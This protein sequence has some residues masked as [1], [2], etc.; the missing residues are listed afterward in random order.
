MDTLKT[1][2]RLRCYPA[3]SAHYDSMAIACVGH[4]VR[5]K[6]GETKETVLEAAVKGEVTGCGTSK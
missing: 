3:L 5:I 4:G 6:Q 2:T 1:V